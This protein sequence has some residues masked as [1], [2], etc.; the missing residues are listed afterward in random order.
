[1]SNNKNTFQKI[2]SNNPPLGDG[3][4]VKILAPAT[5]ANLVCGFDILGMALNAPQD[6]MEVSLLEEPVIRIKHADEYDLPVEPEKN[7]AGASLIAMQEAFGKKIGFEVVITKCI[8]PG[9][10]LGSSAASSAGA[11]VA[12]N[13][14]IVQL[15]ATAS[16]LREA[17]AQARIDKDKSVQDAVVVGVP[18]Y[19]E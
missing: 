10:G 5:V 8:K 11:V 16:A 19:C 1:M 18:P 4:K 9:S 6:I 17:L 7:V 2:T 3:G 14:E 13:H 15:K 12:A